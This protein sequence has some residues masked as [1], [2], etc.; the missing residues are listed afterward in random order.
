[1]SDHFFLSS[2]SSQSSKLSWVQLRVLVSL[3]GALRFL[4]VKQIF[5]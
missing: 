1:M 2:Y 3:S 4:N 5:E